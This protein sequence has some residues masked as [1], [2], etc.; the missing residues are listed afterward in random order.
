PRTG[1]NVIPWDLDDSFT[2]VE[3]TIDPGTF[4]KEPEG[5]HGRPQYDLALSD[6]KWLGGH[7]PTRAAGLE[8]GRRGG[9]PPSRVAARSARSAGAVAEDPNRPFTLEEHLM[10]VQAKREFVAARAQ[11]LEQ[12]LRCRRDGECG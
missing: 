2:R 1:F 6:P 11:F 10:Q 9:G 5:F 4:R 3:P 7:G 12:W 8:R